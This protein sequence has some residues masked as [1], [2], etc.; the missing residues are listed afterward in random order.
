MPCGHRDR[1]LEVLAD[2]AH[3]DGDLL[4]SSS[5]VRPALASH[6]I[7]GCAISRAKAPATGARSPS[8]G[9][10]QVATKL[11][12]NS[13]AATPSAHR[14]PGDGGH[15]NAADAELARDLD[16]VQARPRPRTASA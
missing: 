7:A 15:E 11:S 9:T 14:M 2:V 10:R 3:V 6:A 13:A 8:S 5:Q 12:S 16:G 1:Q 4:Q